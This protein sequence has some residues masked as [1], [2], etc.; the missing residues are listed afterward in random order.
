[1]IKAIR[2]KITAISL[3]IEKL[4]FFFFVFVET[5]GSRA[6]FAPLRFLVDE[7][8]RYP[9][10]KA[11]LFASIKIFLWAYRGTFYFLD[12]NFSLSLGIVC[13]S[14]LLLVMPQLFSP[15]FRLPSILFVTG[16]GEA[17]QVSSFIWLRPPQEGA[18]NVDGKA[19]T[20]KE[21]RTSRKKYPSR[22][23]AA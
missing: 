14:V 6:V 5:L 18:T 21:N 1:M 11:A 2:S 10:P 20:D 23:S 7:D 3:G 17:R 19:A 15:A 22:N 4:Y 9:R 16:E 13:L 12:F 8:I